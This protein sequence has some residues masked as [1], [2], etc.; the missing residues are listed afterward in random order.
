MSELPDRIRGSLVEANGARL[1]TE[2]RGS[3]SPILFISGATGDAGHFAHVADALCDDFKVI[4][5][6]RRGN[7]RSPRPKGW[8]QTSIAEQADDA[9]ALLEALAVSPAVVFGTSGGG[10]ILLEL[11]RRRSRALKG[12]LVHEPALLAVSPSAA[13]AGPELQRMTEEGRASGGLRGAT[14]RFIR[15]A[16]TDEVFEAIDRELRDRMLGNG[17]VLLDVEL[18]HF[19]SYA[20]ELDAIRRAEVPIVVA[21]GIESKGKFMAEGADWL[22]GQ[23]DCKVSWMPGYH[24]PY[25]HP[26]QS[27]AFAE[28]LRPS[29]RILAA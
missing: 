17:E 7:S 25:L 20:P 19:L 5:Y 10:T 24:A 29:L 12:A 9:A 26:G 14:E 8:R 2:V 15:W 23:L 1:Y 11:L 28:A 22:A 27:R 16:G 3:G 21:A 18:S 6:D 4:T 13:E